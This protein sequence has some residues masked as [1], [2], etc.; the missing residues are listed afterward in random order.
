MAFIGTAEAVPFQ[1]CCIREWGAAAEAVPF[2]NSGCKS[3]QRVETPQLD[4]W[5]RRFERAKIAAA[6]AQRRLRR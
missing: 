1:N 6:I 3:E 2:Q 4:Q 5:A